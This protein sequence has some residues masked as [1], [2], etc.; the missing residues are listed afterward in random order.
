MACG[1]PY[2]YLVVT[3]DGYTID[4]QY[5]WTPYASDYSGWYDRTKE[6]VEMANDAFH[7]L[8]D[9]EAATGSY[10]KWNALI[11]LQNNMIAHFDELESDWHQ[12]SFT[13][14]TQEAI[15]EAVQVS[16]EAICLLDQANAAIKS[17]GGKPNVIPDITPP[18]REDQ[19]PWWLRPLIGAGVAITVAAVGYGLYQ[20]AK[21]RDPPA[22]S[23]RAEGAI[24]RRPAGAANPRKKRRSN[25][26]RAA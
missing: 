8:G 2:K 5:G 10:P 4:N 6:L 12:I 21:R 24:A 9:I 22:P 7:Q 16:I 20:K 26:L 13:Q 1:D 11:P 23:T 14:G 18:K 15:G 3:K 19:E 17:Y 25:A